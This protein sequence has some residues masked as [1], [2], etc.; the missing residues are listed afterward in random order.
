MGYAALVLREVAE[1]PYP[2]GPRPTLVADA[3]AD[4]PT[5]ADVIEDLGDEIAT[6]AAEIHAATHRFLLLIAEF[7]RLRGWEPSGQRDCAHW[8]TVRTGLD[9]GTA[10]AKMR[11]AH[12][13]I[14]LPLISAAMGK[15]ELSFSQVRALARVATPEN[16]AELLDHARGATTA[17]LEK[18]VRAWRK[19]SRLD[20]AERERECHAAR[21]FSVFPD[22]E[23]MYVVR[24]RLT[25]EVGALLMRAVEAASDAQ[26][27]ERRVP[28]RPSDAEREVAQ[29]RADAVGLL[30]E[31]ALAAGFGGSAGAAQEMAGDESRDRA[32]EAPLS[33]TRAQRYQV[34]LHVDE[35]TLSAA[36][37]PGRSEL[38]DGTRLSAE[39]ARRLAC[40]AS[41]V[42]VLHGR[43]GSILDVGRK[44][45]TISPA[46]RR[47]LEVRDRGCRF[48]G[49]GCRFTDAHH[50]EHWADGGETSLD[51][52]LLLC[53]F[54][55]RL[56]HEGGWRVQWWGE[57]RPAF[58]NPRGETYFEGGW[59]PPA[60]SEHPVEALLQSNRDRGVQPHAWTTSASQRW[61][62]HH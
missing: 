53:Q 8:L 56:A 5:S 6:L 44:T 37:E 51:G 11:A 52:C 38:E 43:N 26:F 31:R 61:S 20:E 49:C 30:A 21:S 2:A 33:G 50:V 27:R 14:R 7:D 18:M 57:G 1:L 22:D 4:A 9:M 36:R 47:A 32:S 54:H 42:R 12:A 48:P 59:Q 25:P 17:Q 28:G 62:A 16:E 23:G 34:V 35:E 10:Q 60:L 55:H 45:R 15:G 39:S 3:D 29:R 58:I 19:G 46:L 40:D 13:L 24:G 41:V